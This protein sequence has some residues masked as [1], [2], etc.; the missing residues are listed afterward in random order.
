ML[1][2]HPQ[3]QIVL[4]HITTVGHITNVEA[5]AVHKIRSVSSRISELQRAGFHIAKRTCYDVTGQRYT[6]YSAG[7][8]Q[9]VF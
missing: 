9:D 2:L 1:K 5:Q 4:D 3:T 6:R 7:T 8:Y